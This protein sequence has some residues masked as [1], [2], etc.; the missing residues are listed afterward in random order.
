MVCSQRHHASHKGLHRVQAPATRPPRCWA[1]R[2]RPACRTCARSRSTSSSR[3]SQPSPPR[4]PGRCCRAAAPTPWPPRPA[5]GS[6]T[7]WG[8]CAACPRARRPGRSSAEGCTAEW[9]VEGGQHA[10]CAHGEATKVGQGC[11]VACEGIKNV[12]VAACH[13]GCA[14]EEEQGKSRRDQE[15]FLWGQPFLARGCGPWG[16]SPQRGIWQGSSGIY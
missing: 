11:W 3:T 15:C 10:G 8:S 4:P 7:R 6:G 9:G 16:S 14:G 2:T 12:S 1:L 5:R 13:I